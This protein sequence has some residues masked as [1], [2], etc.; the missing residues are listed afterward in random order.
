MDRCV[1]VSRYDLHSVIPTQ[2]EKGMT[3]DGTDT[4]LIMCE[5]MWYEGVPEYM[6]P[7]YNIIPPTLSWKNAKIIG[8]STIKDPLLSIDEMLAIG[9]PE[10]L[11]EE[12]SD[13]DEE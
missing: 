6:Q 7:P 9:N 3:S 12:T 11:G 1:V 5:E 10:R 13:E 4:D 8:I 2:Q